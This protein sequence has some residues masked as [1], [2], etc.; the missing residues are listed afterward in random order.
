MIL[1]KI[2]RLN[3]NQIRCTLNKADLADKH[4]KISELAYGSPK[5]KELFREMMQQASN[6]LG[7][8]V[9]DIPLMIEAI[10]ISSECLILIITKVEDPEELDTRF[11][12]FT[13]D[14]NVEDDYEEDEEEDEEGMDYFS[15]DSDD[16]PVFSGHIDIGINGDKSQVPEAIFDALEGFVNSLTGLAGKTPVVSTD[17]N[18]P[19]A[20]ASAEQQE[21]PKI[22]T[23]LVVFD[24]LNTII[25]ASKQIA[26]FYFSS[27]TLYKNPVNKRFY[28]LFTNDK[29]TAS[30]FNSVCYTLGE[31]GTFEKV[32]K[33]MPYHFREHYKQIIEDDAIQTLSAL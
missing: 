3:E 23:K 15:S 17:S 30:E 31:Y 8:E 2:E 18:R 5:A 14:T 19:D 24:S 25:R 29:N 1:L 12:R 13:R 21:A 10:P 11:S 9:D 33:A 28:L 16:E 27:N 22:V 26:S 6:E 4:L 32:T 20:S 7:F